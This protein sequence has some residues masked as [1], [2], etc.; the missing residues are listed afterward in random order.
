MVRMLCT[1]TCANSSKE[2][3]EPGYKN[4]D[5]ASHTVATNSIMITAT[6]DAHKCR[7]VATIDIPGAF[8]HVYNGKDTFLLLRVHLA[9]LMVQVNPALYPKYIIYGKNN[10]PHLYIK[11]S[12][13]IYGLLKSAVLIYKKFVADLKYNALPFVINPY[14]PC[15]A[16][17]TIGSLQC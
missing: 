11:L 6:I 1:R 2:R 5:G 7:N 4:E 14:E 3:Q 13:A 16:N 9:E 12:K 15:I 8:L 17:A 10:K